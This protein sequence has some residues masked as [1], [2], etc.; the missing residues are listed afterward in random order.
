MSPWIFNVYMDAGTDEAEC[1]RKVASGRRITGAIRSRVNAR[2][3]Q[4]EC[5][6]VLHESLL[7][8]VLTYGSET[9]IWREK[10]ISRIRAVQITTSGVCWVSGDWIKP[11]MHG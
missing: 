8:P 10:G 6:R 5:A 3:L 11:R 4:L 9:M 7:V 1:S 2:S